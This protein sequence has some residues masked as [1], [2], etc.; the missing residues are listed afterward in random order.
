VN[1]R[2]SRAKFNR[3]KEVKFIWS[4]TFL[5]FNRKD[6]IKVE[7]PITEESYREKLSQDQ[8][9]IISRRSNRLQ[10]AGVCE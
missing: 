2:R 1:N 7:K 5:S 3:K 9:Y 4:K 10:L 8:E 6:G